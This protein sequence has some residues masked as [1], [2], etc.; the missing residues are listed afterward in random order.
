MQGSRQLNG[1]PS[2]HGFTT[3]SHLNYGREAFADSPPSKF[4]GHWALGSP[5]L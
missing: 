3:S 1:V 2:E 5:I 4:S